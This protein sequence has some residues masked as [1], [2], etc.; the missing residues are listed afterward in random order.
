MKNEDTTLWMM[1]LLHIN[2][3]IQ[4]LQ[5]SVRQLLMS[6]LK[7]PGPDDLMSF[8]L[9]SKDEFASTLICQR[10]AIIQKVLIPAEAGP[11]GLKLQIHAFRPA[12]PIF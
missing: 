10:R 2:T 9:Y 7:S 1:N 11:G 4:I 6:T 12:Q 3:N 5:E 8:I